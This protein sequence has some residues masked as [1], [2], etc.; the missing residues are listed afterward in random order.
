VGIRSVSR[1]TIGDPELVISAQV[2]R[3]G[4]TGLGCELSICTFHLP[5]ATITPWAI[6][7]GVHKG[8]P[9]LNLAGRLTL[10][11]RSRQ[12]AGRQLNTPS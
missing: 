10:D 5:L 11:Q 4:D 2:A 3:A 9:R 12:N 8:T 6:I 1:G 7:F